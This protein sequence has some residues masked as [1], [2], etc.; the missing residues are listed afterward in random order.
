MKTGLL[1]IESAGQATVPLIDDTTRCMA[2]LLRQTR[3]GLIFRGFHICECGA[4]SGNQE[5]WLHLPDGSKVEINS[6]AVHYLACHR[7][8]CTDEIHK[9]AE[10]A[11]LLGVAPVEP[12]TVEL[13]YRG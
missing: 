13:S 1:M 11:S 7:Q 8:A 12:T 9:V 5:L 4:W 6:L 2:A 10:I 3:G